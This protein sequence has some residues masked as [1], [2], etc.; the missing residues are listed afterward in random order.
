MALE[1]IQTESAWIDLE[2]SADFI[3]KSSPYYA[4]VLVKDARDAARSLNKFPE[5]GR[6]VPEFDDAS[7][8][9]LFVSN[10]RLIYKLTKDSAIKI[11]FIHGARDLWRAW[12]KE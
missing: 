9:E 3:N 4:K 8:R 11:G 6:I 12:D 2:E 1:I 5:R 10:Y 7:I